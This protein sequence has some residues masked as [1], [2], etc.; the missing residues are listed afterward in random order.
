MPDKVGRIDVV[1]L[2]DKVPLKAPA[3]KVAA[4]DGICRVHQLQA[5][6]AAAAGGAATRSSSSRLAATGTQPRLP[7]PVAAQ[8]EHLGLLG[9]E[10][11]SLWSSP[12]LGPTRR[13]GDSV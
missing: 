5:A 12:V 3:G 10:A 1:S 13:A 11:G 6:A 7:L 9:N 2:F 4:R 8:G